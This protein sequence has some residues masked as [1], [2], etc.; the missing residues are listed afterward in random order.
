MKKFLLPLPFLVLSVFTSFAKDSPNFI[1]IYMDDLGWHQTS[2]RM[3]DSEPMSKHSFYE[4]PNVERLAEM[5]MCFSNGYA[6][7]ATC[8]GSRVSIQFGQTSAR[9]QY[10]YVFDVFHQK[11]RPEG[12]AGQYSLADSV[13]TAG[14]NYITAHFGKG[15]TE[16]LKLVNYDVTDEYEEHAPNGNLHGDKIDIPSRKDLPPD[17]P[18]RIYSLIDESMKFLKKNAGKRPFMMMVSHYSVHVPHAASKKY[19]DKWQSE[20]DALEK[21]TDKEELRLFERECKPLYG[22]M[23]EETDQ[24]IGI[25]LDYLKKAGELDNTYFI[26][27]SDNGSECIPRT[28]ENRRYNGP[29]QEG[30]YSC[31][32]GGIRVPFVVAGPGIQ[33]GTYCDIPVVQWDLLATLHDL[34]GN[35]T[36][37][38]DD[39]DGGSL[40][41]VFFKGNQG[42]VKRRAPGIVHHFPSHYQVPI[43][44]IRIGDYKFMRNMNTDEKKLFNVSVDYREKNDLAQKMPEK[45]ASMDKI[46]RAYI[47][48][49]DGGDV[50]DSYQAFYETMDDF[51]G[52]AVKDHERKM[53]E[54]E[55]KMPSDFEHQKSLIDQ[56]LEFKK[57][58]F[59]ANRAIT[60]R[61]ETWPGWY[62]TARKTV[63]A[64]IGMTKGGKLIQKK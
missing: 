31:F 46:L 17:N 36:P 64:E 11:Q 10:R 1:I 2:V 59:F 62:D 63:E 16:K 35:T 57:R 38:P 51:E 7:T 3:K 15:M 18:K 48:E 27:T 60:K 25:L 47:E 33:G 20:Y 6:P 50:K 8:T 37:L 61:Q 21:P 28:K 34:S 32:E 14:K 41:D 23:L 12:Y 19:I 56:E 44:A 9:T 4:T 49:V 52:R 58:G 26:F 54:L 5:G 13:K 40:M 53:K 43:S 24:H 39:I 22:A 55:A 29:L 30:K 45:V 42:K